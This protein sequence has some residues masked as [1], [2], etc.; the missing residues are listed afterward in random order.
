V[1]SIQWIIV[2]IVLHSLGGG[3]A[4]LIVRPLTEPK[5]KVWIYCGGTYKYFICAL[6][7]EGSLKSQL[8]VDKGRQ[9]IHMFHMGLMFKVCLHVGL[10]KKFCIWQVS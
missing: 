1:C 3:L 4:E 5:V 9:I 2:K 6:R 8:M 7:A 10:S